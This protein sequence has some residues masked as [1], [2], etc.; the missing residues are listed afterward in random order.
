MKKTI[1]LLTVFTLGAAMQAS[2]LSLEQVKQTAQQKA[3]KQEVK[4]ATSAEELSYIKEEYRKIGL[5]ILNIKNPSYAGKLK[6]VKTFATNINVAIIKS[7]SGDLDSKIES[8]IIATMANDLLKEIE[9][10]PTVTAAQNQAFLK[11]IIAQADVDMARGL[12]KEQI[13]NN[14]FN[15]VAQKYEDNLTVINNNYKKALG[16][17]EPGDLADHMLRVY[18]AENE[19]LFKASVVTVLAGKGITASKTAEPQIIGIDPMF[20]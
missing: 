18:Q 6:S 11:Q 2:A 1:A 13:V 12:S 3:S 15:T 14:A 4:A 17:F 10:I 5:A 7:K 16:E 19:T 20:Q 8:A 9:A